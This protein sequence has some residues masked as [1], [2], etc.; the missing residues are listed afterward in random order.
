[1]VR[2]AP[3]RLTSTSDMDP[4]LPLW[5][6][7]IDRRNLGRIPATIRLGSGDTIAVVGGPRP[8][9]TQGWRG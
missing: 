5:I 7:W 1:M 2:T 8:A 3:S 9:P 4:L 6:D